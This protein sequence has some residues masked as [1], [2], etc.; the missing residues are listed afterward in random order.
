MR[1]TPC[2]E[3]GGWFAL[4]ELLKLEEGGQF[5]DDPVKIEDS[6]IRCVDARRTSQRHQGISVRGT[7]IIISTVC[8][9][10][11]L[12]ENCRRSRLSTDGLFIINQESES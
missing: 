3:S 7:I 10:R 1:R 11:N 2:D 5:P 9:R 8:S 4:S 6:Q 12:S